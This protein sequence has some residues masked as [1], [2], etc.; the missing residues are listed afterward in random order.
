[1][2][3]SANP[4]NPPQEASAD[5]ATIAE[6]SIHS[7]SDTT[8]VME[9]AIVLPKIESAI[10]PV[11]KVKRPTRTLG[12]TAAG[13]SGPQRHKKP[14]SKASKKHPKPSSSKESP[15]KP[16]DQSIVQQSA[17]PIE[18]PNQSEEVTKPT[19]PTSKLETVSKAA[20]TFG[21]FHRVYRYILGVVKRVDYSS[22]A[23]DLEDDA[24]SI[25]SSLD[26]DSSE[27]DD[28]NDSDHG[29]D[30]DSDSKRK[31]TSSESP[32]HGKRAARPEKEAE[33]E[34]QVHEE[35]GNNYTMKAHETEFLGSNDAEKARRV[36]HKTARRLT[37]RSTSWTRLL[38]W[39]IV[40]LLPLFFI[41][42]FYLP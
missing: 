39:S 40:I 22:D 13:S 19:E 14:I 33:L 16:S 7:T 10:I 11:V 6:F 29:K 38:I 9:E 36:H 20:R 27:S 37:K 15:R 21:K 23:G 5:S 30:S 41:C 34:I 8:A 32:K 17:S 2:V 35:K 18:S 26:S 31:A 3:S 24:S 28:D 4:N 12:S 42:K 25:G 1:M